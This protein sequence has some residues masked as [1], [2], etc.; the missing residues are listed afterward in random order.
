M[1]ISR[2]LKVLLTSRNLFSNW[3]SAGIKYFLVRHDM[4]RGRISVRCGGAEYLLQ[5]YSFIVKAHYDGVLR[6]FCEQNMLKGR[7]W[8]AIDFIVLKNGKAYLVMP[9]GVKIYFDFFDTLV[10]AETWLYEIHFLGHDLSNWFVLDVGAYI[11]DT[12]LYY[13]KRGAFV[14][15]VE[16]LPSNYEA[17]L[18]N[19]ELNPD[20]KSRII[21]INVAIGPEDGYA[22]FGYSGSVDGGASMYCS[23]RHRVRVR[24]VKLSTL[25][26]E[27]STKGIDLKQI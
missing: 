22:E 1:R 21:P 8:G 14:V 24:S 9:D 2:M 23:D 7:L 17:M 27:I 18:K 3:L 5:V 11:G 25:V 20:L 13:A 16:P 4:L 19:I 6:Y 12:A 26:K 15:A 10:I